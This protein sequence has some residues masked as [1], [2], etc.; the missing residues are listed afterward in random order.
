MTTTWFKS[1]ANGYNPPYGRIYAA[2]YLPFGSALKLGS[3]T[4]SVRKRLSCYANSR[5]L[6]F[7]Q[8]AVLLDIETD[9]PFYVEHLVQQEIDHLRVTNPPVAQSREWFDITSTALLR[10]INRVIKEVRQA[11]LPLSPKE[12]K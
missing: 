6:M 1:Y 8:F 9:Y 4:L 2:Q 5:S 7:D 3:T 12:S 10:R 11:P